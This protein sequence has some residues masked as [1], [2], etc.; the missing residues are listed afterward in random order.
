MR[1]RDFLAGDASGP[2]GKKGPRLLAGK[3]EKKRRGAF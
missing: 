1:G 3:E 2:G